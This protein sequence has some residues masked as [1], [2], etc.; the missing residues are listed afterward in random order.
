MHVDYSTD[1][2]ARYFLDLLES[3]ILFAVL[4]FRDCAITTWRGGGG[5]GGGKGS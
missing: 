4:L 3:A 2:D 5:G 1:V